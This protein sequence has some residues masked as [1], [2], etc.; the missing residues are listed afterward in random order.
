MKHILG[1]PL[2]VVR[3]EPAP[4]AVC[5]N[6]RGA[7]CTAAR[8]SSLKCNNFISLGGSICHSFS[9]LQVGAGALGRVLHRLRREVHTNAHIFAGLDSPDDAAIVA[10]PPPGHVRCQ[11]V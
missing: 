7:R 4:C 8:L 1:R 10:A 11:T 9:N 5:C 3:S 6:S 2:D